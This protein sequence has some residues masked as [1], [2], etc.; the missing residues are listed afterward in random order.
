MAF[1]IGPG[2]H[3]ASPWDRLRRLLPTIRELVR[4]IEAVARGRIMSVYVGLSGGFGQLLELPF[5]IAARFG[6]IRI[7]L[8]HHSFA[9]FREPKA[10]A[11]MI[12]ACA[13][14]GSTQVVFCSTMRC[15]LVDSYRYAGPQLI[16]PSVAL[17]EHVPSRVRP[18]TEL[19]VVGYLSNLMRSK[20]IIEYLS[21]AH[22]ME[23]VPGLSFVVAGP[24]TDRDVRQLL[25]EAVHRGTNI[26]YLGPLYGADK[27]LFWDRIDALVFPSAH[28][29]EADPAVV[30]EAMSHGVPVVASNIGCL[31]TVLGDSGT[32][33]D[34]GGGIALRIEAV[35]RNWAA[36][37][38]ELSA[39]SEAAVASFRIRY[40]KGRV[41]LQNLVNLLS[42]ST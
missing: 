4:F 13:G 25:Q 12:L 9:Y 16:I 39:A 40:S 19:R 26:A 15:I 37:G 17:V 34:G 22:A 8:H 23:D 36:A 30:S 10:A 24:C 7:V 32:L 2:R 41:D 21:C 31:S 29:H 33:V 6:G 1:N 3:S 28:T 35:L 20:G 14:P 27:E 18:R 38:G 11:R 42:Q 5:V